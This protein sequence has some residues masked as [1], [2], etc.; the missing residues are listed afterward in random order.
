MGKYRIKID[1]SECFS[2]EYKPSRK[3]VKEF[4]MPKVQS[5]VDILGVV[6]Y[7]SFL[8]V[9]LEWVVNP[10]VDSTY[11]YGLHFS[12]NKK[13]CLEGLGTSY[14]YENEEDVHLLIK[15]HKDQENKK[16]KK[17]NKVIYETN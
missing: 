7:I 13:E 11:W 16:L 8:S 1:E 4:V 2:V 10:I 12:Y 3:G 9:L 15:M 17:F 6:G 14:W 5:H